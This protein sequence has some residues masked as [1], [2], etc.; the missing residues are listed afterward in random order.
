MAKPNMAL[1]KEPP[2]IADIAA[3]HIIHLNRIPGLKV[4]EN[5]WSLSVPGRQL[6]AN[7]MIFGDRIHKNNLSY[8][9]R[10]N[11]TILIQ[12]VDFFA[13][14]LPGDK[15]NAPAGLD[16][17]EYTNEFVSRSAVGP[18]KSRRYTLSDTHQSG[19]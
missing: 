16:N 8:R 17:E 19:P 12:C 9:Q 18:V 13:E 11:G 15:P 6:L 3:S 1:S 10:A 2:N 5:G 7:K 4:P 14:F